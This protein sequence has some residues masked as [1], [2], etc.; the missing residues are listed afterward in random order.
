M[1]SGWSPFFL[2]TAKKMLFNNSENDSKKLVKK[3][4]KDSI[5]IIK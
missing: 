4:V 3:V 5:F 2:G 1:V